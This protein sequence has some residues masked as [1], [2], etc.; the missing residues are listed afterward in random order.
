MIKKWLAAFY[1]LTDGYSASN[2]AQLE[3]V[4]SLVCTEV[5]RYNISSRSIRAALLQCPYLLK[6]C[7]DYFKAVSEWAERGV[8]VGGGDER[9]SVGLWMSHSE[10]ILSSPS[11]KCF[12]RC[13]HLKFL[14]TPQGTVIYRTIKYNLLGYSFLNH[15]LT[16]C[17]DVLDREG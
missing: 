12:Y 3:H 8:G 2:A 13:S 14:W 7:T 17:S 10:Q 1:T 6:K 16:N 9:I 5:V 4:V 11:L 15:E